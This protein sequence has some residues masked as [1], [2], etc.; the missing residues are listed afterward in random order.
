MY[1]E[2]NNHT[3]TNQV[4]MQAIQLHCSTK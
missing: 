3:P 4:H 2:E 1:P